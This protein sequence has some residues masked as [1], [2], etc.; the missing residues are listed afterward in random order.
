MYLRG[1]NVRYAPLS[2][3]RDFAFI[4]L[5]GAITGHASIGYHLS[6][7]RPCRHERDVN[8]TWLPSLIVT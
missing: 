4:R 5:L 7:D 2:R 6:V 1:D 3:L 8:P